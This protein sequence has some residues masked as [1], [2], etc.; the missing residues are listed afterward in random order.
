MY[1]GQNKM[2]TTNPMVF[3]QMAPAESSLVSSTSNQTTLEAVDHDHAFL[4]KRL[5][6]EDCQS[7]SSSSSPV[8]SARRTQ[9]RPN[10]SINKN[11]RS[12]NVNRAKDIQSPDDL[13]YYLERRR[14]N[15]E[16]SK[17]SRAARKQKFDIMDQQWLVD[18][19]FRSVHRHRFSLISLPF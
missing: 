15:N 13:S 14:K 7:P 6:N 16:A 8:K 2:D 10:S 19:V 18:T 5:P 9:N 3:T 4:Y 12:R 11:K 1:A 17:V